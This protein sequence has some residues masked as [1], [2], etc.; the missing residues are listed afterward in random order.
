MPKRRKINPKSL[1]YQVHKARKA[2]KLTAKQLADSVNMKV[3]YICD[4]ERDAI[5]DVPA[6]L[7]HKIALELG[8]TIA[9][10]K[11]LPIRVKTGVTHP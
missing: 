6:D 8:T 11:G 5:T 7:L 1:G 9:D 2:A 4:L 3:T 10:L